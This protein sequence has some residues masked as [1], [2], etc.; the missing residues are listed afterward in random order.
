[1]RNQ[2]TFQTEDIFSIMG[3]GTVVT[4]K[5]IDGF[6]R[7]GMKTNINGKQS[8]ILAI[9]AQNKSLESLTTGMVAGLLL[10]NVN[11]N[12]IQKGN[13]YFFE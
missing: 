3:R 13:S 2:V 8:E 7:K 11:K 1:M 5:L 6:L 4:G 10:S 12:D 9:E